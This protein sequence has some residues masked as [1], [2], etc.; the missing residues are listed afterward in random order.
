MI[1]NYLW[2]SNPVYPL[3]NKWFQKLP[4]TEERGRTVDADHSN[5]SIQQTSSSNWGHFAVRKF[6]YHESFV[7]ILLIPLRVFFQGQDDNPKYFDG[8]LNPFLLILSL[9]AFLR[10]K[11]DVRQV[12]TEKIF[13][14]VFACLFLLI[15]FMHTDMRIRYILPIIPALV[16]L[17]IYGIERLINSVRNGV[18]QKAKSFRIWLAFISLGGMLFWNGF[19]LMDQFR[20]V[21][22]LA[23]ISGRMDRDTYIT[24]FRNEYPVLQYANR[25]L[26]DNAKILGIFLGNRSYYCER[27]IVFDFSFLEKSVKEQG[28]AELLKKEFAN[29]G[30]SHFIVRQDLFN[31]WANDTFDHTEGWVLKDFLENHTQLIFSNRGYGLFTLR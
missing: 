8:R 23:Y 15:T 21:D 5:E 1:R 29:R 13:L 6:V 10:L 27:E 11:Q 17:S 20:L 25:R 14:L 9:A 19:Y 28:A 16:I 3:Y 31:T 18:P 2:T 7:E 4:Q 22:P 30:I 26:S 24:R 12:R